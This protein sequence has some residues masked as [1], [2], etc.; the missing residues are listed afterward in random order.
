MV[1]S[2][3][4]STVSDVEVE[5]E[6]PVDRGRKRD[7]T[8]TNTLDT[9][10][11]GS[12]D[13]GT[14]KENTSSANW[15]VDTVSAT[16]LGAAVGDVVVEAT[17]EDTNGNIV[18]RIGA[19]AFSFPVDFGG[20]IMKPGWTLMYSVEQ[21]TSNTHNVSIYPVIRKPEPGSDTGGSDSDRSATRIDSFEDGDISE[22][23][24][25]T[26]NFSV[27]TN[28]S[29]H[30]D[31][32][33]ESS[34]T[35]PVSIT[36]TSGLENYPEVGDTIEF[37]TKATNLSPDTARVGAMFGVEGGGHYQVRMNYNDRKAIILDNDGTGAE[38]LEISPYIDGLEPDQWDNIQ[39]DWGGSEITVTVT[40]GGDGESVSATATS[41][42]HE[43]TTGGFGWFAALTDGSESVRADNAKV[44]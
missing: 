27:V 44:V 42:N 22:Y 31:N 14:I 38:V 6:R 36:S 3:T 23:S 30:L 12:G 5:I 8:R 13:T 34:A 24:G 43:E 40:P 32:S 20:H 39:V 15:F 9:S 37:W 17:I 25:D 2:A 10:I 21:D 18:S 41:F 11:S 29:V 4:N 7:V 1:R 33:L 35:S 16:A 28:D 19:D 26:G